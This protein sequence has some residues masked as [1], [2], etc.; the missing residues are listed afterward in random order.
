MINSLHSASFPENPQRQHL[1]IPK[2]DCWLAPLYQGP[3]LNYPTND[4]PK[5]VISQIKSVKKKSSSIGC[6]LD[7]FVIN[8]LL[9][10]TSGLFGMAEQNVTTGYVPQQFSSAYTP[11]ALD[12]FASA[13][14]MIII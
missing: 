8:T 14:T 1:K 4:L 3:R 11:F 7:D 9:N 6:S 10:K 13:G 12:Q 5:D 2:Q